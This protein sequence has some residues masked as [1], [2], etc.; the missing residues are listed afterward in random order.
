MDLVQWPGLRTRCPPATGSR[1]C[2][3]LWGPLLLFN[4][5]FLPF[6][7]VVPRHWGPCRAGGLWEGLWGPL[8][9]LERT[10]WWQLSSLAVRWCHVGNDN[11]TG[12]GIVFPQSYSLMWGKGLII[13]FPNILHV[14][15][16]GR[17]VAKSLGFQ[18]RLP[19]AVF[20]N[21]RGH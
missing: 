3:L 11:G 12:R 4:P 20:V 17:E 14:E 15:C 6:P 8:L 2:G 16:R 18:R 21:T 9:N 13:S 5:Q 1:T 19:D 10:G 7:H